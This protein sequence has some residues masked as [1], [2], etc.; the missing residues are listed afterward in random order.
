M[1]AR[2]STRARAHTRTAAPPTGSVDTRNRILD[3]ARRL[4]AQQHAAALSVNQIAKAAGVAH[5]TVYRYFPT[6]EAL[7]A[8][9]AEHPVVPELAGCERWADVPGVLRTAWRWM[10]AHLEELRGE[11]MVP[12][13]IALRRARLPP[14]RQMGEAILTDAGVPAGPDRDR[15]IEVIILL[16][17]STAL[18]ELVD[19]HGHDVDTAVDLTLDAIRRLV[20]TATP[21]ERA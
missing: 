4:V 12:G 8:A 10:A 3:A 7:V 16:T 20:Q 1:A 11:R 21:K 2:A 9:I 5:R 15:L 17:S 19:R 6:K 18:L 13:G 14:T